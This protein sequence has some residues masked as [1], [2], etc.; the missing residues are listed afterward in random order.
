MVTLFE[1]GSTSMSVGVGHCSG[2]VKLFTTLQSLISLG[3]HKE[4]TWT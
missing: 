4:D 1:P 2:V 3:P